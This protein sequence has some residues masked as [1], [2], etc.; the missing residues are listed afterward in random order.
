MKHKP[1]DIIM[2]LNKGIELHLTYDKHKILNPL[3][4]SSNCDRYFTFG[5]RALAVYDTRETMNEVV[6]VESDKDIGAY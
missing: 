5:H 1:F 2:E 6:N 3:A 4:W